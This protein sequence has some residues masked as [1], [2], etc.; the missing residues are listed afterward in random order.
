MASLRFAIKGTDLFY[1]V[2]QDVVNPPVFD[3]KNGDLRILS[4]GF[5]PHE[6]VFE[7]GHDGQLTLYYNL[8]GYTEAERWVF[9]QAR[10]ILGL[11]SDD[12]LLDSY[13]LYYVR[14]VE[15]FI[16]NYCALRQVPEELYYVWCEMVAAKAKANQ[17]GF[18]DFGNATPKTIKDGSQSVSYGECP[19]ASVAGLSQA[20]R[21]EFLNG[22]GHQLRQFRRFKWG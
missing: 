10:R 18:A 6:S 11:A 8:N 20:E 17:H 15:R 4:Y 1:E 12:L 19:S 14:G 2:P 9:Y 13:L 16:C 22:W 5:L 3:I 7:V 21:D